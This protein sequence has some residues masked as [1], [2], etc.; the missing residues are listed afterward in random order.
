M[1]DDIDDTLVNLKVKRFLT[2]Y[3]YLE[4]ELEETQ[5]MFDQYNKQFL[6][7]YYGVDAPPK[8]KIIIPEDIDEESDIV[9]ANQENTLQ[10]NTQQ[11]TINNDG[12][13]VEQEQIEENMEE[14]EP[15][16]IS[17]E[18][19]Q[20]KKLYRLL[21]LKTHP[22]KNKGHEE[23]F[24]EIKKAYQEKNILKLFNFAMK[25][26]IKVSNDIVKKCLSL[27]E[28]NIGDMQKKIQDFKHTLAWQ[29]CNANDEQKVQLKNANF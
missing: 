20:L 8:P 10:E 5:Y 4:L 9:N 28:K 11:D 7:E 21:S 29:W 22:D 14:T 3:E 25:F 2:Q 17:E 19:I 26:K 23:T 27:F 24:L 13:N 6:K 15:A 12:N 18:D 16:E 1:S